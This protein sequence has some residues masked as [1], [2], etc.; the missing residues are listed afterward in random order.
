MMIMRN[1]II[2]SLLALLGLG[3]GIQYQEELVGFTTTRGFSTL[4]STTSNEITYNFGVVD[5]PV[6]RPGAA[7]SSTG[8]EFGKFVATS[9]TA[10]SVASTSN[11]FAITMRG[12]GR[13]KACAFDLQT[14]PNTGTVSVQVQKNGTLQ[15][16]KYC[17]LP[18]TGTF[19]TAGGPNQMNRN[20]AI[21]ASDIV[22]V[23]GDRIGII[24]SSSNLNAATVDGWA[25][26]IIQLDN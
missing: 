23:A 12:S 18:S 17:K 3:A 19:A 16:G 22:F 15:T 10:F 13:V 1:K 14:S 26:L 2:F 11:G 4:E 8:F 7:S 25:K 9:A 21:G 20:E 6:E 5:I 24:A